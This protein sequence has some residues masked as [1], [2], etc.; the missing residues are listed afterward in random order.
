[1]SR[2]V[3]KNRFIFL[4]IEKELR[5][6]LIYISLSYCLNANLYDSI[7]HFTEA[8]QVLCENKDH[9]SKLGEWRLCCFN[10]GNI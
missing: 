7:K 8:W 10:V 9:L 1:M 4:F 3:W 5:I 6:A 2:S